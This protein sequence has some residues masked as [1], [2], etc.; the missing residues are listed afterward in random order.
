MGMPCALDLNITFMIHNI[1]NRV[2]G[3]QVRGPGYAENKSGSYM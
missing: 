1:R 3:M 2:T